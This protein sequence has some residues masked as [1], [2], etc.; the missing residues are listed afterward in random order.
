[1]L[2]LVTGS[3]RRK[4]A[5]ALGSRSGRWLGRWRAAA[6]RPFVAA[7]SLAA[8]L[9]VAGELSLPLPAFAQS[10]TESPPPDPDGEYGDDL[11]PFEAAGPLTAVISLGSQKIRV[12]DHNG[13]IASSKVSTGKRGHDTPEGIFSIIQRK[14]EHNSNL[15]DDAEMPFMQ[16]ITWSGVALH[17]GH[18][19]GYRASHGCIRLPNGFAERLFRT[20]KLGTRV[21]IVSHDGTF[22]PV[23]HAA[24]P[25]PGD[26]PAPPVLTAAEPPPSEGAVPIEIAAKEGDAE[27]TPQSA[28][29]TTG[30]A[31]P[32]KPS[33]GSA[34]LR[35]RR[36]VLERELAEA[37][38]VA[39]D[40]RRRVRPLRIEQG[41]AER[42][43]RQATAL[44]NRADRKAGLLADAVDEAVSEETRSAAMV[45][46]LDALI[47]LVV[48]RTRQED[49]RELA[50]QKAGAALSAQ[51][52][53]KKLIDARQQVFNQYRIVARRLSPITIFVSRAAGRVYVHQATHPVMDLPIE[54]Q[55]SGRPLGTH[56]FTA[57]EVEGNP[58]AVRWVGL[59]L[60]TPSGGSPARDVMRSGKSRKGPQSSR[61]DPL[62]SGRE[63]LDRFTLPYAVLARVMP[64]LQPG[65]TVIVSDLAKS[66]ENGPGTDIIVQ[67]RGEEAAARSIA[68]FQQR[69]RQETWASSGS[70]S[71]RSRSREWRPW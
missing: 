57:Q 18:V 25:Q 37:T 4:G 49:A 62:A 16:R 51:D 6:W 48:A 32:V 22:V 13:L 24:L 56:I 61:S 23:N 20:T 27:A 1:M 12:F 26:P 17:E 5:V 41:R 43:L 40:A 70:Y 11:E 42:A 34:E 65:S 44:A 7:T 54:I 68:R 53:A 67:T 31:A 36:V 39:N 14:V 52:D 71:P 29:L 50:A 30:A 2:A 45:E 19:P 9:A 66:I 8:L 35:R 28:V 15:Y 46:H 47:D 59:T 64:A 21:V 10:L 60:E 33:P 3:R 63:A 69:Q 58:D 55:D 38:A